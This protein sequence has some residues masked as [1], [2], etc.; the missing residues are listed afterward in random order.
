M[1][2]RHVI[3]K[4][5][6]IVAVVIG[7]AQ[8]ACVNEK[9]AFSNRWK[10]VLDLEADNSGSFRNNR[11]D[12]MPKFGNVPLAVA[13]AEEAVSQN[14]IAIDL[15]GFDECVVRRGDTEILI[16]NN[17]WLR[18]GV[19]DALSLDMAAPQ[20]AVKVFEHHLCVSL[21]IRVGVLRECGIVTWLVD[22]RL[23]KAAIGHFN[24]QKTFWF[25]HGRRQ[26]AIDQTL[27]V[28]VLK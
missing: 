9:R 1:A 27:T 2:L 16:Q 17:D 3:E 10:I 15:E 6:D 28:P 25:I 18:H 7:M 21:L 5:Q 20:Q 22:R 13:K 23:S 12:E 24:V 8:A 11:C 19:D 4:N 26:T 14:I